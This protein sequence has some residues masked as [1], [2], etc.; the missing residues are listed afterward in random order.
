MIISRM[1]KL[2]FSQRFTVLPNPSPAALQLPPITTS[3]Y[4][5]QYGGGVCIQLMSKVYYI[6]LCIG[7][8]HNGVIC[9]SCGREDLLSGMRWECTRC[10]DYDLCSIC[11][12]VGRHNLEHEFF[13]YHKERIMRFE[14]SLNIDMKCRDI[15]QSLR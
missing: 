13:R 10:C 1:T 5:L 12:M 3:N 8:M 9:D 4:E 15:K 7:I 11:Y 14:I 2:L 6:P